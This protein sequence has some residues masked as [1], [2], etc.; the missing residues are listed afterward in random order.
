MD[1]PIHALLLSLI[2]GSFLLYHLLRYLVFL[3]QTFLQR[4]ISLSRFGA[5]KPDT[6]A[7]ITGP[8]S[9]IG[10]AF[11]R[12]LA[13]R[14]LNLVL[15]GRRKD[16]L[17]A[18]GEEVERK[19]VGIKTKSVALD[20]AA[21]DSEEGW[22]H[23]AETVDGLNI[24][25]LVNNAGV[26]HDIPVPFAEGSEE[27]IERI[28]QVVSRITLN[29]EAGEFVGRRP[30]L[31]R[32]FLSIVLCHLSISPS[33]HL[34]IAWTICRLLL[35]CGSL[36]CRARSLSL[37]CALRQNIA[38]VLRVTKLVLPGMVSRRR[39]LVLN[40]GSFAAVVPSPFLSTYSGSKAFLSTWSKCLAEEVKSRGV[41]VSCVIPY[42]V[43][44]KMSKIRKTSALV[45][46][47]DAFV[48]ST[49]GSIGL[50]KGAMGRLGESTPYWSHAIMDYAITT[51]GLRNYAIGYAR[52]E[53]PLLFC[54]H[55]SE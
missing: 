29:L 27:E 17:K 12:Q 9:G 20:L 34:L 11:A 41:V 6:W 31:I 15:V 33:L 43:S 1:V 52:G 39:G 13:S 10:E 37:A 28:L 25:V 42:F 53:S 7:V 2:G 32:L 55:F 8:T 18:L 48:K 19:Y 3:S 24:G 30:G 50:N 16:A 23:L 4:G 26:S 38:S 51:F 54:W 49:L 14:K 35:D 46:S 47:P 22:K 5:G 36:G 44:T 40:L 21:A 45:P